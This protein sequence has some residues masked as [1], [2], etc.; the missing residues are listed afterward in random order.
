MDQAA[1]IGRDA[2]VQ[3]ALSKGWNDDQ[4]SQGSDMESMMN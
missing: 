1:K 2:V 3:K 4:T